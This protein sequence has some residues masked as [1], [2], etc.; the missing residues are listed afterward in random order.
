MIFAVATDERSLSVFEDESKAIA[1]CEGLDVEAG[2]WLFWDDAGRPLEPVFSV[3]NRR[4]MFIVRNGTYTLQLA[5][6][7][8]HAPLTEAVEEVLNYE[9][10]APLNC[11]EGVL[12]HISKSAQ[13]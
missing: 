7:N 9:A 12:A 3:P 8:H 4:G 1:A 11:K 2:D 5:G 6:D 10:R 13:R